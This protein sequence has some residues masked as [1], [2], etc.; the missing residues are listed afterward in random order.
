VKAEWEIL[1]ACRSK[2][3]VLKGSMT[4]CHGTEPCSWKRLN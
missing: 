3:T 4:D 2:S 1:L